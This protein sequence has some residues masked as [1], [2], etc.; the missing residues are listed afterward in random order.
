MEEL[1][2]ELRRRDEELDSRRLQMRCLQEQ[3]LH[4]G[5]VIGELTEQLQ[6][7]SLQLGQ[8]Q[9]GPQPPTPPRARHDSLRAALDRRRGAKAG[10]SAEPSSR[11]YDSGSLPQFSLEKARV[12]K[13]ARCVTEEGWKT[14]R[15]ERERERE[16]KREMGKRG[17]ARNRGREERERKKQRE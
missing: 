4:Q 10:V 6:A 16:G 3:L 12:W 17:R 1:E 5:R 13:E 15:V 14:K 7:H 9:A 8:L 11:T 2:Q